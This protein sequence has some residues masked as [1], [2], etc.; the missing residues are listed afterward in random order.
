MPEEIPQLS[1]ETIS[2]WADMPYKEIM[3]QIVK[4]FAE[5]EIPVSDIS[6]KLSKRFHPT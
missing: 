3:K 5:D 6:G 4:L 1:Q 2:S